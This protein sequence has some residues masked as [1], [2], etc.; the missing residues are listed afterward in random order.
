MLNHT[1]RWP[2]NRQKG[3]NLMTKRQITPHK[4]GRSARLDVRIK[5]KLKE[6]LK[7]IAKELH[8]TVADLVEVFSQDLEAEDFLDYWQMPRKD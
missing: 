5:P 8:I 7:Q 2:R 4:G 3:T 6:K 1:R